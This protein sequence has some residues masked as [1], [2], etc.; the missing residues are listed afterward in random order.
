MKDSIARHLMQ[1]QG[2]R[3]ILEYSSKFHEAR[4][5]VVIDAESFEGF[6]CFQLVHDLLLM[7]NFCRAKLVIIVG[8]FCTRDKT[9]KKKRMI[10]LKQI[11]AVVGKLEH[12]FGNVT[13]IGT[14]ARAYSPGAVLTPREAIAIAEERSVAIV[15][16]VRTRDGKPV[17]IADVD[18]VISELSGADPRKLF[19]RLII[20]SSR[21]GIFDGSRNFLP[22]ISFHK[23]RRMVEEGVEEK[24]EEK[25]VTGQV[26]EMLR[27]AVCSIDLGIERVHIVNGKKSGGLL[28]ELFTKDGF[29]TMVYGGNYE[30]I[31]SAK[32]SDATG[33][34]TLILQH[35]KK[36]IVLLQSFDDIVK[37]FADFV[38][39]AIDDHIVACARLRCFS[40]ENKAFV[41]S[42]VAIPHYVRQG[43]GKE[44]LAELEKRARHDGMKVITLVGLDWWLYHGFQEGKLSDLPEAIK[45]EYAPRGNPKKVLIKKL[46]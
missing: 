44:L 45:A 40:E 10:F 8:C 41:S 9:H 38:V 14:I 13:I 4:F 20:V 2:V 28:L 22:Q 17:D 35:A 3:E 46:S 26:A 29:G 1:T 15:S 25:I 33:I 27:I 32:K 37:H 5:Y 34:Y 31:R 42:V 39:V 16:A 12:Y 24:V 7:A 43:I 19:S 23:A 6:D 18:E 11:L 30:E 21:D 36:G